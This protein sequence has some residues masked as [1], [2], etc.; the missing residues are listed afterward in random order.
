MTCTDRLLLRRAPAKKPKSRASKKFI[1]PP[2][3]SISAAL[4]N[5]TLPPGLSAPLSTSSSKANSGNKMPISKVMN[6]TNS[7]S[8]PPGPSKIAK[9]ESGDGFGTKDSPIPLDDEA[10][11]FV[12][13]SPTSG[14][15]RKISG[16]E[17]FLAS[18]SVV[19]ADGE[20]KKRKK[21]VQIVSFTLILAELGH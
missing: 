13:T 21:A 14:M 18:G 16:E 5:A 19:S 17:S 20:N 12:T 11:T 3:V 2:S 6:E 9:S 4:S 10:P 1:L 15:K 8:T 7:S